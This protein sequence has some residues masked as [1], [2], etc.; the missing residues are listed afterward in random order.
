VCC[1]SINGVVANILSTG[2]KSKDG[3]LCER[4]VRTSFNQSARIVSARIDRV[5]WTRRGGSVLVCVS[6]ISKPTMVE[7]RVVFE[8]LA[9]LEMSHKQESRDGLRLKRA[10]E[11]AVGGHAAI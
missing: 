3:G 9:S 8:L 2:D 7:R 6:G 11:C 5:V 10:E 4:A 1:A